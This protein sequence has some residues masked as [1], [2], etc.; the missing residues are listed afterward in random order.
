MINDCNFFNN[1]WPRFV[2]AR[3]FNPYESLFS[4]SF[5]CTLS[6]LNIL[7]DNSN[8]VVPHTPCIFCTQKIFHHLI[9]PAL[10][11]YYLHTLISVTK[12]LNEWTNAVLWT[13]FP[14]LEIVLKCLQSNQISNTIAVLVFIFYLEKLFHL[15]MYFYF[16]MKREKVMQNCLQVCVLRLSYMPFCTTLSIDATSETVGFLNVYCVYGV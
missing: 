13:S 15:N 5:W 2:L 14:L 8:S 4:C 7:C 16:S 10:Y 12:W 1:C 11:L 6:K 9:L 3:M